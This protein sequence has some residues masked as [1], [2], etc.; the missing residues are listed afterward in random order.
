MAGKEEKMTADFYLLKEFLQKNSLYSDEIYEKFRTYYD[1]VTETNKVMNLT[2]IT[3]AEEFEKKHFIDS[4]LPFGE[5]AGAKTVADIGSG[6]GFPAIPL[7]IVMPGVSFTLVDSLNKRVNFLNEVIAKLKLSNCVA[8]HS[9]AEDFAR[10]GREK[11]DVVTARAVASLNIL[12][13]YTAPLCR[14]GGRIIA[15]KGAGADE[16]IAQAEKAACVLGARLEKKA[17]FVLPG[18]DVRV[19]PVYKKVRPCDKK[20]PRGGNK[21]RINPIL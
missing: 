11:F 20:Y 19:V 9:R 2:A 7:A 12:L 15:Y 13:E 6:A 5:F 1:C 17:D 3:R 14:V 10:T 18:G 16:E 21:P 8:V 4:L